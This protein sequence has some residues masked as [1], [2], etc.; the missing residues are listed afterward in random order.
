MDDDQTRPPQV[1]EIETLCRGFL[2]NAAA[3][4][5]AISRVA[6]EEPTVDYRTGFSAGFQAGELTGVAVVL[7]LLTGESATTLVDEARARASVDAAFPVE[8][9]LEETD[10]GTEAA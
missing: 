10:S 4:E 7:S 1:W 6:P 2:A 3:R 8:F 9:H 5:W